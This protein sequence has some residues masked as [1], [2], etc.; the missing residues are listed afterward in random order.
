MYSD[1]W[2]PAL[3]AIVTIQLFANGNHMGKKRKS[4]LHCVGTQPQRHYFDVC[5]MTNCTTYSFNHH[6]ESPGRLV[7]STMDYDF[8]VHFDGN[9]KTFILHSQL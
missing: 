3:K 2:D 7:S 6:P 5:E 8:L 1:G 9:A 4:A